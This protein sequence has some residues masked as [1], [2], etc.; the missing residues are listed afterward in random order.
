MLPQDYQ[1][2]AAAAHE[3]R[4]PHYDHRL[5]VPLLR[6]AETRWVQTRDAEAA[7]VRLANAGCVDFVTPQGV[8]AR[9]T[10]RGRL[11]LA[12]WMICRAPRDIPRY[13][14]SWR[15]DASHAYGRD[16]HAWNVA[17][18]SGAV[19]LAASILFWPSRRVFG[20]ES[21][22]QSWSP[23]PWLLWTIAAGPS[24]IVELALLCRQRFAAC[25]IASSWGAA[26]G[27]ALAVLVTAAF[28]QVPVSGGQVDARDVL[29]WPVVVL[30]YG[31][32]T[33]EGARAL[34]GR[35]EGPAGSGG[36]RSHEETPQR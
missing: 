33:F 13:L 7:V 18:L 35:P 4:Q 6:L 29:L 36:R 23:G 30:S 20:R 14:R 15:I 21:W 19:F 28:A 1:L 16:P 22:D 25:F 26:Y 34:R 2:L 5:G 3:M 31:A 8:H 24:V 11:L 32:L 17:A 10:R 9:V 12:W 27:L